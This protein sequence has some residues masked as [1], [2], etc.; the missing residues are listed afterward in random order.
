MTL[1]NIKLFFRP[2]YLFNPYPGYNMKFLP[3]FLIFFLILIILS[4]V[5]FVIF[6]KNK[7]LP[8]AIVWSHIYNWFLWI[9]VVG[10]LL[11]FFRYEGITY[12]SMRFILFLWLI[13]F[14]LWGGYIGWFVRRQYKKLLK[15]Y[16]EK[17]RKERYFKK[18]R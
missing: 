3:F 14:V 10:L 18:R 13:I 2:S 15:E 12:L 17:K 11:L 9:G 6:K 16:K 7:K 8:I 5:S 4:F 1:E